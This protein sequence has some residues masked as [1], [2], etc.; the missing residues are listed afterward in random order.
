[1]FKWS[2]TQIAFR[3]DFNLAAMPFSILTFAIIQI[4][5]LMALL[6]RQDIKDLKVNLIQQFLFEIFVSL[7][8]RQNR[9][10]TS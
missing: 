6:G 5:S 4:I 10:N 3:G 9:A 2:Q 7:E 1:L 8:L